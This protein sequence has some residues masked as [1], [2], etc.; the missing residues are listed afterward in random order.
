MPPN[1]QQSSLV[2]AHVLFMDIVRYSMLYVDQ[3]TAVID[4][5]EDLIK[6]TAEFSRFRKTGQLVPLPAGD[7][8]ALVFF[9]DVLSPV[10]CA[11]EL[12]QAL[13][14]KSIKLRMGI[15][16]GPVYRRTAINRQRNV[17]GSGIN[18][19]QRVM[20]CGD[21]GH[22]LLSDRVA[23]YL[24]ELSEWSPRLQPLG[25]A[26]AKHDVELYLYN[27]YFD[28]IGNPA[29]PRK[30]TAAAL[31]LASTDAPSNIPPLDDQTFTGRKDELTKLEEI[32]VKGAG[33]KRCS[34]IGREIAGGVGK[35]T[36][37]HY[38][39]EQHRDD[40]RDGIISLPVGG[41]GAG[42]SALD[43]NALARNFLAY[44]EEE[45]RASETAAMTMRRVCGERQM[46]LVFDNAD[47]AALRS[48]LPGGNK[49]A[50]IVTT[51][52]RDL[53]ESLSIPR[54]NRIELGVLS[55][56]EA[57]SMLEKIVG[58]DRVAAELPAAKKLVAAI[59]YLPLAIRIAGITLL[60][61][62]GK[63]SIAAYAHDLEDKKRVLDEMKF[64]TDVQLDLRAS[65]AISLG[66]LDD[67][68]REFFAR[69]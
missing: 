65:I 8:V 50:V 16:S 11:V 62:P 20:D 29:L 40:F 6:Q 67:A 69:L 36:L 56:E 33:N 32:L 2:I 60:E 7:G 3:Q 26:V 17:A 51:R 49:C 19:A 66:P 42:T 12:S 18:F 38:F 21:E 1:P 4:E 14:G 28:D 52:R 5:L 25:K 30:L 27:L 41:D 23:G 24:L 9:E 34:V 59:S 10:R 47:D 31:N 43:V 46:L 63:D 35:T 64:S 58:A 48:L 15:H 44:C 45:P 68:D 13:K 37:A 53:V 22:I 54:E 61:R 55:A 57:V 39:A